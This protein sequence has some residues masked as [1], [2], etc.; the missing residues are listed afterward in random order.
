MPAEG[1]KMESQTL[2]ALIAKRDQFRHAINLLEAR[3]PSRR[4]LALQHLI[5][6]LR[7]K[8][9]W[10]DRRIQMESTRAAA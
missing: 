2:S 9:E 8:V 7:L 5:Q 10:L 4:E 6:R 1:K 3:P